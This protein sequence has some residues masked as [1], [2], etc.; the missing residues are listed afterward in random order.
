MI[1]CK[2]ILIY[3]TFKNSLPLHPAPVVCQAKKCP[4]FTSSQVSF[5]ATLPSS[6]STQ[7]CVVPQPLSHDF[8]TA[9]R[10]P[11]LLSP[12]SG[13]SLREGVQ[14]VGNVLKLKMKRHWQR[15]REKP[16]LIIPNLL[17]K[18]NQNKTPKQNKGKNNASEINP[19]LGSSGGAGLAGRQLM[20]RRSQSRRGP[21]VH[22]FVAEAESTSHFPPKKG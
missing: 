7:M 3:Y 10:S 4:F 19:N 15:W 20:G 2:K 16:K 9:A 8:L 11:A 14:S 21:D 12:S 18:R 13:L 5:S 1:I 17:G 6:Q 22:F